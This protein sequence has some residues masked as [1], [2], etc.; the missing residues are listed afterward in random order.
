MNGRISLG[1]R[2]AR[3]E[4]PFR[5]D[6]LKDSEQVLTPFG[7]QQLCK[8]NLAWIASLF[9]YLAPVYLGDQPCLLLT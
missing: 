9:S 2:Y 1:R 4:C 8:S 3:Q 5:C 7:R 6:I